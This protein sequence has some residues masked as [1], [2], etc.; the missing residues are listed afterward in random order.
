MQVL[1]KNFAGLS[2]RWRVAA[3]FRDRRAN[4]AA[5]VRLP[6]GP[7]LFRLN[8]RLSVR[9]AGDHGS[10]DLHPKLREILKR[11]CFREEDWD[12]GGRD[13]R[14]GYRRTG[15]GS[16]SHDHTVNEPHV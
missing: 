2:A 12:I 5:L 15:H 1:P 4:S 8:L 14:L 11:S 3:C 9:T 16:T 6:L 10:I 7:P 13:R